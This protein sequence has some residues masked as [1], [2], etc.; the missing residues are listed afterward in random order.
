MQTIN[1]KYLEEIDQM[2]EDKNLL[3]H[4]FYQAWSRGELSKE[5][6]TEYSKQYYHHVKAFPTYLS[7]VHMHT[8]C[9][10]TRIHLLDNLVEEE[11]RTSSHPK[12]WRQFIQA[13]G[14]SQEDAENHSA[15]PA[16]KKLISSF[17]NIC[18]NQGVAEGIAALYAYESQIPDICVS[19]IDGLKKVYGMTNPKDWFYFTVHIEAD[20]EHAAVERKL[21]GQHIDEV[22]FERVKLAVEEILDA[23]WSF[24]DS[25]YEEFVMVS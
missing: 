12:L 21:L 14:L 16:I 17:R 15:G 11:S 8:E 1:T 4:P 23:L 3:K 7:A 22:N 25:L 9:P 24:L 2:I 5:C 19:K 20:K 6:L 13:F 18:Q 10:E